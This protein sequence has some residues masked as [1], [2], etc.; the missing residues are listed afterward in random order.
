MD[1]SSVLAYKSLFFAN[2]AKG[3]KQQLKEGQKYTGVAN[4]VRC[5]IT[6]SQAIVPLVAVSTCL[7]KTSKNPTSAINDTSFN[8]TGMGS[9]DAYHCRLV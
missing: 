2:R 6:A 5:A 8:I 9:D 1:Y 3:T 7:A 4:G